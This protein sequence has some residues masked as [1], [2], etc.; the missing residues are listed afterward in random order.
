MSVFELQ[1][2]WTVKLG[3]GEEFDRGSMVVGNI[4]NSDPPVDKIL[5]GS[6]QGMLRMYFPSKAQ[7]RVED[8]V[9]EGPLH[10]P[11]LQ[12]ALGKF[13][14]SSRDR[15]GVAVLHPRSLQVYEVVPQSG[16]NGRINFYLLEKLYGHNLG[17]DGKHFTAYNMTVGPFGGSDGRD[18]IM[19]QSMDGKLQI[20]EQSAHAF[21]RQLVDCLV[22]GPIFYV[23]HQ[24][25]FVTTNYAAR[26]ECYKYHVLANSQTEIGGKESKES[27]T[28]AFGLTN[29]R[30]AMV[31]WR[32][33]LGEPCLQI[34][35]GK[36]S[37]GERRMSDELLLLTDESMF[38]IKDTGTV[39][40]QR[41]LDKDPACICSYAIGTGQGNNI[42]LAN[43]DKTLQIF[44]DMTLVWAAKLRNVPV[45]LSVAS[46]GGLRGM[47]VVLDDTGSLSVGYLGTKPPIN[48]VYSRIRELDYDK[49]DEEHRHLLQVIRETQ[50]ETKAEP[51]D[52][53]VVR[54]QVSKTLDN[55]SSALGVELP[56]DLATSGSSNAFVKASVRIFLTYNGAAPATNVSISI[57]A[58]SFI[59]A[60]PNSFTVQSVQGGNA[61][62]CM[63]KMQLFALKSCPPASLDATVMVTYTTSKGE[64]RAVTHQITLPL[65][66]A[67]RLRAPTKA[68]QFKVVLD[69][70]V[71]AQSLVDVFDD[72]LYASQES[73][74]DVRETLGTSATHAMGFQFWITEVIKKAG[75]DGSVV[76]VEQPVTCSILVS[77]TAGRY[78]IQCDAMSCIYLIARELEKRLTAKILENHPEKKGKRLV[79]YSE[80]LPTPEIFTAIDSHF[81][82]R[83]RIQ[84]LMSELNDS[85]HQFRMI[86]KRLLARF[87]DRNP[88]PLAG[89]DILMRESYNTLV[90][91][92]DQV[93]EQQALLRKQAVNLECL[94]R[95]LALLT[96]ARFDME[97][98]E[99]KLLESY[100]CP[101]FRDGAE[102]GWEETVDASLTYLLKTSMAKNAKDTASLSSQI[103]MPDDTDKI[104][105]HLN[106]VLDRISKGAKLV[107]QTKVGASKQDSLDDEGDD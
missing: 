51:K 26:I 40:Q 89:L 35:D 36:F 3:D 1:E 85:S 30:D 38:L 60:V 102:Q 86:E 15:I 93:Q 19:V 25:S 5:V 58:P 28:N 22:P 54:A 20:F 21:T 23:P 79:S 57:I 67:C 39:L 37:K 99:E 68:A 14:P 84:Q 97:A 53:L 44:A 4:D 12:L 77:K 13:I 61:T 66:V 33:N 73:G 16:Q 76:V 81:E 6:F 41:R 62:P 10:Q 101:E 56:S 106:M 96:A 52:I 55:D 65:T 29:V 46:F 100:L 74:I 87:K 69:T 27:S 45:S 7:Y 91:L 32:I 83:Q 90:A 49:I 88:T 95:L 9:H 42:V 94:S 59:H 17:M 71:E 64:P 2:W 105:K 103:E 24:D 82:T 63:L 31:E 98:N 107:R 80:Q 72:F 18:M 104:K 70:D 8:L 75:Q 78:R 47:L 92:G 50:S 11:I 43:K 48:A 34:I